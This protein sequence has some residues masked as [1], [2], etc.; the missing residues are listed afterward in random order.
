MADV[1]TIVTAE[2]DPVEG[3]SRR[4][5]DFDRVL[6][7]ECAIVDACAA[8]RVCVEALDSYLC[9]AD[10]K[11]QDSKTTLL[12][13]ISGIVEGVADGLQRVFWEGAKDDE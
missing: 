11:A 7:L 6:T 8:L 2:A 4:G 12:F 1:N 13:G 10:I 3:A 9:G 5:N